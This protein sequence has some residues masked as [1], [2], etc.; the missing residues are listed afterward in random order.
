MKICLHCVLLCIVSFEIHF[1][2]LNY[3]IS[4]DVEDGNRSP[5]IN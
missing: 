3:K 1:A 2:M 4:I 5:L